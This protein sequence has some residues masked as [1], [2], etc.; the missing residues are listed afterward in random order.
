MALKDK[1]DLRRCDRARTPHEYWAR[2]A[3]QSRGP[4]QTCHSKGG[5]GFQ[6]ILASSENW[7]NRIRAVNYDHSHFKPKIVIFQ[8]ELEGLVGQ[9]VAAG[10]TETGGEL[11]GSFSH[12][13]SPIISLASPAA[14]GAIREYAHFRQDV[15][16]IKPTSNQLRR[17]YG[18]Q[19]LG[20][21]HSHH[22]LGLKMLSGGDIQSMHSIAQKNGFHNTC[23]L[24]VTFDGPT[25][26]PSDWEQIDEDAPGRR[27]FASRRIDRHS[28][29]GP[30][31]NSCRFGPPTV[32]AFYYTDAMHGQPVRCPLIVIPGMSP[33]RAAV[34]S[35]TA[36]RGLGLGFAHNHP[37][38]KIIYDDGNRAERFSTQAADRS[39]YDVFL[40]HIRE[41]TKYLPDEAKEEISVR[42][43]EEAGIIRIPLGQ[44]NNLVMAI[45]TKPPYEILSVMLGNNGGSNEPQ[46]ITDQVVI[47][48]ESASI[49]TIYNA[50]KRM[51][52]VRFIS[53]CFT[54]TGDA[55][56]FPAINN[57]NLTRGGE[58]RE[59]HVDH[60]PF[61]TA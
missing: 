58:R 4:A 1:K 52:E 15:D 37:I 27:R 18:V 36:L 33:I 51:V 28:G 25:H 26:Y 54:F 45:H 23:Q 56:I 42:V 6:H 2:T 29:K 31:P 3:R 11:Y 38:D 30:E 32:H 59:S 44:E 34:E 24:L 13:R 14:P 55:D 60:P 39:E 5:T 7:I 19:Y 35:S 49:L 61:C 22:T 57:E 20:N 9:A 40:D 50:T 12:A 41:Q 47:N 16:Y 10:E 43:S 46:D 8:S 17:A 48:A 21:H 53:G